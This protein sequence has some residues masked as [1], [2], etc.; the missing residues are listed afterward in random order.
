MV[1]QNRRFNIIDMSPR[2]SKREMKEPKANK[3]PG[4]KPRG[5]VG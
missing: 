1:Q 4:P 5:K 2:E 3:T